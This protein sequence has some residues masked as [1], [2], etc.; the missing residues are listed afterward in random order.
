MKNG[1]HIDIMLI[2]PVCCGKGDGLAL[3]ASVQGPQ[4]ETMGNVDNLQ[5]IG[6]GSDGCSVDSLS[7]S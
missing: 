6:L 5:A 4:T 2:S 3:R 1:G 7:C